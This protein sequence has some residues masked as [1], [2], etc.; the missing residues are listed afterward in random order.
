MLL[1]SGCGREPY[2]KRS[3][4][5]MDTYMTLQVRG[6]AE[7]A[8]L[9]VQELRRLEGLWDP[10]LAGSEVFRLN[11]G[12]TV[13]VDG[14]TLEALSAA[15]Q[16]SE[17]TQGALDLTV[18][19]L[20]QLWGFG[21]E[22]ARVPDEETLAQALNKVDYR[23]IQVQDGAV[24]LAEGSR[25]TFGS[26]AKG[27]AALHLR[28][29]LEK[30]GVTSALLDLGGSV[31]AVGGRED[32]SP[33]RIGVADPRTEGAMLGV[34]QVKDLAVITSSASQ[35]YFEQDGMRYHHILDPHTGF[36]AQS[37]LLSVTVV[38]ENDLL[39]DALSTALFVV[40]EEKALQLYRQRGDFE[41]ILLT[42]DGRLTVTQ[43]LADC[44]QSSLPLIQA[45]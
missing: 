6:K 11:S 41:L 24:S 34:L 12:E 27:A 13:R 40:G 29:L 38:A 9:C 32:G 7:T 39:A 19:T 43:G 10:K 14:L 5:C 8:Q 4:L 16:V 31:C 20:W 22:Q 2:E 15:A 1:L 30:A 3:I 21:T 17:Q 45:S 37:G 28:G 23:R 44:F 42:Q 33:W 18:Q 26:V 36:P 35:R 25:L